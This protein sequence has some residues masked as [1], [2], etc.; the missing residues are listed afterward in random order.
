[1]AAFHCQNSTS[2]ILH[3][4]RPPVFFNPHTGR[5]S[6]YKTAWLILGY[7]L[8]I[9]DVENHTVKKGQTPSISKC[10]PGW[11][12]MS[13]HCRRIADS[14]FGLRK[15]L[16]K[17]GCILNQ[18]TTRPPW[19]QRYV[20]WSRSQITAKIR[21]PTQSSN[22][23]WAHISSGSVFSWWRIAGQVRYQEHVLISSQPLQFLPD[24]NEEATILGTHRYCAPWGPKCSDSPPVYNIILG[25]KFNTRRYVTG[26]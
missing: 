2:F 5:Q 16:K 19:S 1:M 20:S 10:I 3:T 8:H 15:V 26:L 18:F 21:N 14:K 9:V 6:D 23:F 7:L 13:A 12:A 11:K 22:P 4:A 24:S 17:S 25:T